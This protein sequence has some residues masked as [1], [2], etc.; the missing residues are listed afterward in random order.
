MEFSCGHHKALFAFLVDQVYCIHKFIVNTTVII[1]K[2]L[3]CFVDS[4][5]LIKKSFVYQT[6]EAWF[7]TCDCLM[8]ILCKTFSGV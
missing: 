3:C 2:A 6:R 1:G 7:I 8:Y 5:S 4:E